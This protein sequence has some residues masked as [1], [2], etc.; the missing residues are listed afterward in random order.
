[1]SLAVSGNVGCCW[2]WILVL[3]D[4]DAWPMDSS[5]GAG[6]AIG[7]YRV[8]IWID[9]ETCP[10]IAGINCPWLDEVLEFLA[11]LAGLDFVG[12][13]CVDLDAGGSGNV[14][15]ASIAVL[16]LV[17]YSSRLPQIPLQDCPWSVKSP[18][19]ELPESNSF[20]ALQ[21][22]EADIPSGISD[23]SE[24]YDVIESA[25]L[26]L[27]PS[28]GGVEDD[29]RTLTH[30][31]FERESRGESPLKNDDIGQTGR[32]ESSAR[33]IVIPLYLMMASWWG[34]LHVPPPLAIL[35]LLEF[36]FDG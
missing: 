1:M 24:K 11:T 17:Y 3:L 30:S 28:L 29:M 27:G 35:Q 23:G 10:V 32:A 7:W 6:K 33:L 16:L 13:G 8:S 18:E 22:S 25:E 36:S 31:D 4:A 5:N 15:V 9:A 21:C 20:A 14:V 19:L 34:S 2:L 12:G 26:D